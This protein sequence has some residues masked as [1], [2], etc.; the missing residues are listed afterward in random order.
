M[1]RNH[2]SQ[3][4]NLI[5]TKFSHAGHE[6]VFFFQQ[7]QQSSLFTWWKNKKDTFLPSF[8]FKTHTYNS[9]VKVAD[10]GDFRIFIP[11]GW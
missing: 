3:R 2:S 5:R 10:G 7:I 9:A 6:H 11:Q 1:K 4:Q 8:S